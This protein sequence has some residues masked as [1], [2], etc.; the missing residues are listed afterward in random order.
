M[1]K[2]LTLRNA[3]LCGAAVLVLA[4]FIMS[5]FVSLD[6]V[7]EGI[8]GSYKHILWGCDK[9]VANGQVTPISEMSTI[10]GDKLK[11]MG[12][13]IA[14]LIMMVVGTVGAI[15]VALF[16]KKPF[17][18]YVVAGLGLVVLA[19]GIMQFWPVESFARAYVYSF[20]GIEEAS[21]SNIDYAIEQHILLFKEMNAHAP[22]AVVMGIFGC[23]SGVVVAASQFLPEKELVK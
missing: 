13:P 8:K 10:N 4:A 11:A 19:G 23:L 6:A 2:Y 18:K 16:L 22:I 17:A 12:L 15:L 20:K 3:V 21:Q 9:A 1:K 7:A 5:F 14:G